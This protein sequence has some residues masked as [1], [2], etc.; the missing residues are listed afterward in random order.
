MIRPAYLPESLTG[1]HLGR[2]VWCASRK[3]PESERWARDNPQ[4]NPI[5]IKLEPRGGAALLGFLA[6]LP[7]PRCPFP[8]KPLA[9]SAPVSLVTIH[10]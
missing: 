4:T 3:D 6:L 1:I 2:E 5:T 8:I 10:F 9:L 7:P